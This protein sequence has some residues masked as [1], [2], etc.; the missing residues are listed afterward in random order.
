LRPIWQR[1]DPAMIR[2]QPKD[3]DLPVLTDWIEA[4]DTSIRQVNGRV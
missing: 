3:W 2:I 1:D 4:L